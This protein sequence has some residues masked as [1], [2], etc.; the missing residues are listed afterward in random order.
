MG[1]GCSVFK[2]NKV[3]LDGDLNILVEKEDLQSQNNNINNIVLKKK[4][5][6]NMV[7]VKKQISISSN[8][9][10]N[11][12]EQVQKGYEANYSNSY[13]MNG[14][15]SKENSKIENNNDDIAPKSNF[16][17]LM[18]DLDFSFNNNNGMEQNDIFNINYINI[19]DQ[20]NNEILNYLNKI[21]AEPKNIIIDIDNILNKSKNKN[22]NKF[23]IEID[24]THENIV[25]EDGGAAFIETKNFLNNVNPVEITFDLNEDLLIDI[26]ESDKNMDLPLDKKINKIL[27]D[28][29]NNI[30]EDY[31]NCQFFINFIKDI[32]IGLLFLLSQNMSNFRNI[33]FDEKYKNFN[34]TWI[35]E[36]KKIFIAF[37]CFA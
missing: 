24:E 19:K 8:G 37:L 2:I 29:K 20:Y 3:C 12:I 31:P 1:N 22:E 15:Q 26:S 6:N 18:Q 13:H 5:S 30:I 10:K 33:L 4:K 27:K 34:L 23:Q 17:N 14:I 32:K 28:K 35:K 7:S 25:L 16:T 11:K 36:K 21:R 9:I